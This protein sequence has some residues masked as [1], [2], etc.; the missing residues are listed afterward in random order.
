[1]FIHDD[2][3]K[4]LADNCL[5]R[6]EFYREHKNNDIYD[7]FYHFHLNCFESLINV[8]KAEEENCYAVI[9]SKD[10]IENGKFNPLYLL[11]SFLY[12]VY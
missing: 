7:D 5:K 6:I 9:M 3:N 8:W 4:K 12:Q 11:Q 10:I 1:M 2:C